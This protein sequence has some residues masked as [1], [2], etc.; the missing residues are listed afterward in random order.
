MLSF[1][2]TFVVTRRSQSGCVF[3]SGAFSSRYGP[4]CVGYRVFAIYLPVPFST[5]ICAVMCCCWMVVMLLLCLIAIICYWLMQTKKVFFY[6]AVSS[7]L[8][9]SKRFTLFAPPPLGRPV[10]SDTN[11]ATLGEILAMQQLCATTKHSHVH[12]CLLSIARYSHVHHCL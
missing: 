8:D 10:H 11:S 5:S 1:H 7:P 12:H 4:L 3:P 6:S 2:K 9:R